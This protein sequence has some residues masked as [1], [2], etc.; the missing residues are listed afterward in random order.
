M[1]ARILI[2]EEDPAIRTLYQTILDEA[3]YTC[4]VYPTLPEITTVHAL[5]P[6]LILLDYFRGATPYGWIFLIQLKTYR[7]TDHIPV[8]LCTANQVAVAAHA[9]D[10][11]SFNVTVVYQPFAV[12]DLLGA[13]RYSLPQAVGRGW[14]R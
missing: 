6:D 10:L 5:Q 7:E 12:D 13:V 3:G 11:A 14:M 8:L 9:Q 4:L 1:T 2:L